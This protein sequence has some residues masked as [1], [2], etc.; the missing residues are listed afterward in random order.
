VDTT[1]VILLITSIATSVIVFLLFSAYSDTIDGFIEKKLDQ[2]ARYATEVQI[3]LGT[4]LGII[5]VELGRAV[6]TLDFVRIVLLSGGLILVILF[7]FDMR[8]RDKY[9][10]QLMDSQHTKNLT[11]LIRDVVRNEI[12]QAFREDR[13]ERRK[14]VVSPIKNS[15][16]GK[17]KHEH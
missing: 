3:L 5:L 17:T 13:K 8:R 11:A 14:I 4:L 16:K 9:R 7:I 10:Q 6:S 1:V 12:K 2:A 15:K